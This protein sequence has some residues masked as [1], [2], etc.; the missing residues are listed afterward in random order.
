MAYLVFWLAKSFD[1]NGVLGALVGV[2]FDL[3]GVRGGLVGVFFSFLW[4]T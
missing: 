3:D 1:Q 2:S 4:W